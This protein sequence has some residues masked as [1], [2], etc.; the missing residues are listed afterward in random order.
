[1]AIAHKEKAYIKEFSQANPIIV[2]EIN[3]RSTFFSEDGY[4]DVMVFT[5]NSSSSV[6]ETVNTDEEEEMANEGFFKMQQFV[7]SVI[8]VSQV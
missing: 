2:Q 7:M 8:L 6:S 1:M 3:N 4:H 5:I